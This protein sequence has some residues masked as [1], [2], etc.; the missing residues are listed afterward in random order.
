M[1]YACV[2]GQHSMALDSLRNEAYFQELSKIITSESV[3]LDVGAG[4]GIHGLL[5]AKLGAKRVYLVEPEAIITI[6][7]EI[8]DRNGFGKQVICLK[9]TIEEVEIP[10]KVD[11]ITSV[12]TGNFLLEEDLL[13]SL[14][15][16]RDRYLKP[17][18]VLL[19]QAGIMEAVPVCAPG[20]YEAELEVWSKPHFG[21]DHSVARSYVSQSIFFYPKKI[22]AA[23]YLSEPI[24]LFGLDFHK[25]TDTNCQVSAEY[26][27]TESGLCHGWAGWFKMQLGDSWLSTAPHEPSLHWGQAFLPLDPPIP[28]T[29]GEKVVFTLQRPPFADWSWSVTTAQTQQS[30]STFFSMPLTLAIV[31]KTSMGY[32]PQVNTQGEAAMYVLAHS[33]GSI[34]VKTLSETLFQK[35]PQLFPSQ[36]KSISFVQNIV[37]RYS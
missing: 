35:Y 19:P 23:R 27:M 32:Q 1:S 22:D 18:G 9:G 3:V 24:E 31:K 8:A 2:H 33:D 20:L 26:T 5:A 34:S 37:S 13:P 7:K 15:H 4:L 14:F 10:E 25:D 12:F 21:I 36:Q 30:H 6:A 29:V 28:L 17:G 11:V 16:A